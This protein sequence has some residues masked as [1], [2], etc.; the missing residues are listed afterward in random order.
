M[1]DY[2]SKPVNPEDSAS[3]IAV[4]K[5]AFSIETVGRKGDAEQAAS[6]IPKL[7]EEFERF[8]VLL[9]PPRT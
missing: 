1:D 6:L 8:K 3:A 2:V 9:A 5:V 7:Q 4:Q